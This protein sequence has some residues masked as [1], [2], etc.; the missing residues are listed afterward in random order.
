MNAT[1]TRRPR[2]SAILAGVGVSAVALTLAACGSGD[3]GG[4][5]PSGSA[6]S[7]GTLKLAVSTTDATQIQPV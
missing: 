4:S 6:A 5:T 3:S 1:R 7:V 2:G